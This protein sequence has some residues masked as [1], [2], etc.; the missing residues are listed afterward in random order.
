MCGLLLSLTACQLL[1]TEDSENAKGRGSTAFDPYS[2]SASGAIKL[3]LQM[4][5]GCA[6]LANGQVIA[7]GNSP[8]PDYPS[9][10]DNP[11]T[12]D[13]THG[14]KVTPT[15]RFELMTD[16]NY[17]LN[18]LT[19]MDSVVNVHGDFYGNPSTA[20]D[21]A[22]IEANKKNPDKYIQPAVKWITT[23]SRLKGLDWS[24]L[25]QQ[26]EAWGTNDLT[27]LWNREVSFNNAKWMV[28]KTDSFLVE[29]LDSEGTVRQSTTYGRNEFLGESS[30]AGHTRVAWR[31]ENILAPRYPGDIE[32]RTA[33]T[34]PFGVPVVFRTVARVDLVGSTNPF[35]SFRVSGLTGDGAIRVTWSLL[36]NQPFHFPVT[37]VRPS[38]V[39]PTCFK[40]DGT[41][42]VC[43]FGVEPEIKLTQ[44][45]NGQFYEPGETFE[46][47]TNV[48][49]G[50]GNLLHQPGLLP[51]YADYFA[52]KTNGLTYF[53]S[54]HFP[55]MQERDITTSYQV[56]G[57]LQELKPF[58]DVNGKTPFF[59]LG[60]HFFSIVTEAAEGTGFV[61]LKNATWP[62]RNP[63]TLPADAKPGTYV[64][65]LRANR[66]FMGERVAKGT[67]V[68]FQ[69]GSTQK[70]TYPN[71][72]GN[73]QICH[74]G[75]LSLDN[76]RHG[77]SVDHVESCK[78][79]HQGGS[80]NPGRTQV[81]M[82]QIHMRSNKYT[83]DKS[84]CTM[85]HLSKQSAVRP[86]L[87]VC[88]SCHPSAHGNE[89]F[90]AKFGDSVTPNRFSNCAESCHVNKTPT[91]H[92]LPKN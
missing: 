70:T 44:P 65:V 61:G 13:F 36:P 62:N 60:N 45:K 15:A 43:G 90:N 34:G 58:G 26:E 3:G 85:C 91:N 37:F 2:A 29:V 83:A 50:E 17:F 9:T 86:S 11:M 81:E 19:L 74:R 20:A 35:K 5:N 68:F 56:G 38:D 79:C 59:S 71:E 84:D 49:D 24:N 33:Q 14:A 47:F 87:S 80:D 48:R 88:Q 1:K 72:V 52:G 63:V 89:Y 42:V 22:A 7:K 66:Q 78:L 8:I 18:Q 53:H 41:P 82:H 28:S 67:T 32:V 16:T 31:I 77:F 55:N 4:F 64:A 10:C 46:L 25:G 57:P 76:L 51:S 69:V 54:N 30:T 21:D 23:Q 39:A 40:D 12:G 92:I 6:V 75:V 73:C 27:G